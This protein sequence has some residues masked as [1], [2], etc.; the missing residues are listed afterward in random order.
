MRRLISF[1][2]RHGDVGEV[3][4]IYNQSTQTGDRPTRRAQWPNAKKPDLVV[5]TVTLNCSTFLMS[6]MLAVAC[7]FAPCHF[8]TKFAVP[9]YSSIYKARR[10]R[11]KTKTETRQRRR[12]APRKNMSYRHC[13]GHYILITVLRRTAAPT[14]VVGRGIGAC[15][16][17]LRRCGVSVRS[18][19]NV[20]INSNSSP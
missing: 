17:S 13:T 15:G 8:T 14:T 16:D 19:S 11:G 1:E 7:F 6:T 18:A 3:G 12:N 10:R 20:T 9:L 2:R 5:Y 4:L